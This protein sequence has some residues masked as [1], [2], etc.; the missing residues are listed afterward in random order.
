MS[1]RRLVPPIVLLVVLLPATAWAD[2]QIV[3]D[4]DAPHD[5]QVTLQPAIATWNDV[6][7]PAVFELSNGAD[8]AVINA[9]LSIATEDSNDTDLGAVTLAAGE[10]ATITLEPLELPG[11]VSV[12]HVAVDDGT[13]MQAFA[14]DESHRPTPSIEVSDDGRVR[15]HSDPTTVVSL[16][17]R[18]RSWLGSVSSERLD[19][20][21]LVTADPRTVEVGRRPWLPGPWWVDVL[22]VD[23]AGTQARL[24]VRRSNIGRDALVALG[25]VVAVGLAVGLTM[26]RRSAEASAD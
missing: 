26:R 6:G 14:V 4:G 1:A 18:Q 2:A 7:M 22:V 24:T 16:Q 13:T 12:L 11:P 5:G 20:P 25:L 8:Q 15:L 3:I 17:V 23:H 19:A 10:V 21:I 9:R